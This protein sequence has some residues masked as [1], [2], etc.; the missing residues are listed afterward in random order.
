MLG[1]LPCTCQSGSWPQTSPCS[2]PGP[3]SRSA[4]SSMREAAGTSG[5]FTHR[6][7]RGSA[8]GREP[9]YTG[10]AKK[11]AQCR[12]ATARTGMPGCNSFLSLH[13]SCQTAWAVGP[14]QQEGPRPQ[15]GHSD[16][17][18]PR[19]WQQRGLGLWRPPPASAL[20]SGEHPLSGKGSCQAGG[21]CRHHA[22]KPGPQERVRP[23]LQPQPCR[24]PAPGPCVKTPP[25]HSG[26]STVRLPNLQ[27]KV[28]I[29]C[30]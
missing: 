17:S 5:T 3:T 22:T 6:T 18:D 7:Q 15:R 8:Q 30:P 21:R 25:D 2:D 12:S 24:Q 1:G 19:V 4:A 20:A 29:S 9:G 13:R 27:K 16:Y 14:E 11:G 10:S 23:P 28:V 26:P